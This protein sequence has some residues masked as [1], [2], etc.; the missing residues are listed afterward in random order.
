MDRQSYMFRYAPTTR[1]SC[2]SRLTVFH[3]KYLLMRDLF[4]VALLLLCVLLLLLFANISWKENS[5]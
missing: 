4:L 2:S 1:H 3:R 5:W